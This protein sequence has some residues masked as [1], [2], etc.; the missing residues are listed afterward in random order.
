MVVI[1]GS[2]DYGW[3][4]F[5]FFSPV[6]KEANK[7]KIFSEWLCSF[8]GIIELA[9]M[10][11]Y[12]AF[13]YTIKAGAW[14]YLLVIKSRMTFKKICWQK[15]LEAFWILGSLWIRLFALW[16]GVEQDKHFWKIISAFAEL[17][18]GMALDA[19]V[20]S[21]FLGVFPKTL[22]MTLEEN[23]RTSKHILK[24]KPLSSMVF[25]IFPFGHL[26]NSADMRSNSYS[27]RLSKRSWGP[28][29]PPA[30]CHWSRV[31]CGLDPMPRK[32]RFPPYL[33]LYF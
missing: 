1:H 3:I 21:F 20:T 14:S 10:F 16:W 25:K 7:R 24:A 8:D 6:R 31:L 17:I 22:P 32:A 29:Q 13:S 4:S 27:Q 28:S 2:R 11:I 12:A 15:E 30:S 9:Y 26:E 23:N 33:P 19:S 5:N 18:S